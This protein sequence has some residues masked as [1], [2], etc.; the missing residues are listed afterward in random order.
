MRRETLLLLLLMTAGSLFAAACQTVTVDGDAASPTKADWITTWATV[1]IAGIAFVGFGATLLTII[2]AGIQTRNRQQLEVEGYVRVD[3]G[4]PNGTPDYKPPPTIDYVQSD[5]LEEVG[6]AVQGDPMIV[7]WFRNQQT[8]PLGTAF[9]VMATIVTEVEDPQGGVEV[10]EHPPDI[11]YIEPGKCV[12][13]D[14]IRFP[15]NWQA[16]ARVIAITYRNLHSDGS[17]PKH[18]RW[19]CYYETRRFVMEPW[20]DP[21][22]FWR[23]WVDKLRGSIRRR[24]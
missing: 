5:L 13:V 12:R 8:H 21:L 7:A 3:L 11:A 17:K 14:L 20:S 4:P 2:V 18:G 22:S 15:A 16:R 10:R 19:E 1:A 23:D 24:A 6:G 9:G